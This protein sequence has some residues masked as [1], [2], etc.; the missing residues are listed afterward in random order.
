[1]NILQETR[2]WLAINKPAGLLVERNPWED[3]VEAQAYEYLQQREKKPYLGIVHRLDRVT[4]GVLLLAKKK[5]ALITLNEQFRERNVQKTYLALVANEPPQPEAD[6]T[7]WL[8]K[9]YKNKQAILHEQA[10][11]N[12]TKCHLHYRL[13]QQQQGNYLLEIHPTTGKFHQ[14]RAQLAAIG[15]PILGDEKYG[16][17]TPYAPQAVALHAWQLKFTDP[18]EKT[19][20]LIIAPPEWHIH[21]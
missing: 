13:L 3:S 11:S 6:L 4:S 10:T 21:F 9:D 17:T 19:P 5:S 8:E 14:I 7:H 20:V 1:M 2:H 15:C 12:A 16:S 18:I